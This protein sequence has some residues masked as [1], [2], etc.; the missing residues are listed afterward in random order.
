MMVLFYGNETRKGPDNEGVRAE[1]VW[2]MS[3]RRK[4]NEVSRK[5]QES[6][7][8][9]ATRRALGVVRNGSMVECHV[10]NE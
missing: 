1:S 5:T 7:G 6:G 2:K 8:G 4:G 3:L 9:H 10:R